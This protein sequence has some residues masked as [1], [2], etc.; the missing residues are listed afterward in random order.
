MEEAK[1]RIEE[2]EEEGRDPE[3]VDAFALGETA[4]IVE[5]LLDRAE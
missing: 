1:V 5:K 2:M 4:T 3:E